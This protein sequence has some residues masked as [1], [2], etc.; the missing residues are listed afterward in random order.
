MAEQVT[1]DAVKEAQSV[2]R[3]APIDDSA[4]STNTRAAHGDATATTSSTASEPSSIAT[5]AT[6][7][8]AEHAVADA[9]GGSDTDISRP[10]SVDQSKRDAGHVRA[11]SMK[12]P[13][14]FKSVSVTKNFLA[15]SV[16]ST[17]TAR[18][19]EKVAPAAPSALAAAPALK[20][21]L[22]AKLGTGNAP[23][24]L[25][26]VNGAGSGPDASKVWNKN[27]PVP[28]PPP[29]QFTDEELKQQYGI[30]LAT[31]LQADEAG[32]EAKWADI[33]DD[34]D[35]WAP[36]TVQWMDGT[37]SS[38]AVAEN[39]PPAVEEAKPVQKVQEAPTEILRP[40]PAAAPNTPKPSVTGGPKTIL[41]PGAHAQPGGKSS[42]VLKGQPE[43]PTLV[44]KPSAS[45]KKSPWA[46]LPPVEKASPIQINPPAQQAPQRFSQ[47]ESYGGYDPMSPLPAKEIAPDDFNRTWRDDNRAR[48]ELF[49]SQSGRYEPVNE[50]RRGSVRDSGFRQQPAVLQRPSQDGPAEPS[51]AFQQSRSAGDT[52]SWGG[53]RR[54]NSSNVSGG[55]RMSFDRRPP[56]MPTGPMGNDRR[57]S[58]SVNGVDPSS[59]GVSRQPSI[60]SPNV[61]HAHPASPYGSVASSG[62]HDQP[63]PT[64]A[65]VAPPAPP[66]EDP[67]EAQK[68]LMADKIERARLKKQQEREADQKEEAERKERLAKRLAAMGPAKVK[69]QMPEKVPEQSPKKGVA[70]PASVQSP[71]KPPVPTADGEIAQYGMMK[72][73]HA[74]PVK[75][76]SQADDTK[77]ATAVSP[78]LAKAQ[79]ANQTRQPPPLAQQPTKPFDSFTR[80]SENSKLSGEQLKGVAQSEAAVPAGPRSQQSQANWQSGTPPQPRPWTS[81]V[82]GPPTKD[83]ALGNG[84]FGSAYDRSQPRG[85]QQQLPVQPQLGPSPA[86][87]RAL[88]PTLSNLQPANAPAAQIQ[89]AQTGP[90]AAQ[91]ASM[92]RPGPIAP[93][94]G[95]KWDN[96]RTLI[97]QNDRE[98]MAKAQQDRERV[99]DAFRPEIRETYKNQLGQSHTTMHEK[100][101][102]NR[103]LPNGVVK[104][105]A[106]KLA[107]DSPSSQPT[108]GQ[109]TPLQQVTGPRASR[110]FPRSTEP[111][112]QP[113]LHTSNKADS[114]PP[115][116]ETESHPAF[117]SRTGHPL[118][119]L[120]K[121]SPVVRL[122]RAAAGGSVQADAPAVTMPPRGT[123]GLGARPLAMNPEWQARFNKLLEKP[124]TS[125]AQAAQA[126]SSRLT[127]V[128][129]PI[130]PAKIGS[131]PIA[132]ASKAA[133]D[134]R[135]NAGSAT[136]SLPNSTHRRKFASDGGD[137]GRDAVTRKGTEGLFEDR[138]FGS[139]P[140]VKLSKA[141]HLAANQPPVT[142]V[143]DDQQLLR[144][145]RMEN[146]FTQRRL[147]AFDHERTAQKI[148][149]VIRLSCMSK[150]VVKTVPRGRRPM[151]VA[152]QYNKPKRNSMSSGVVAG[153]PKDRPRKPSG[154]GQ[155]DRPNGPPRPSTNAWMA[156]KSST[157]GSIPAHQAATTWA[158][159]AAAPVH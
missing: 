153:G 5:N 121:P 44:S 143:D 110:F 25:G 7:D 127:A 35:D 24:T 128:V 100:V 12:K 68:K 116:P 72:V 46:T 113:A 27:Q 137:G 144:F 92:P 123:P 65:P 14:T 132:A 4:S 96:F 57:G 53:G 61:A 74:Q 135:G 87:T 95:T 70:A 45:E 111:A 13:S 17:P 16:V 89:H 119:R 159:R 21:R 20:P 28:V 62:A 39:E 145:K 102:G 49:N 103:G 90:M 11:N 32:K 117:G 124:G 122:P 136:V 36:D 149:V 146:P 138:E 15:K 142:P 64:A 51:A 152:N 104:D 83:R 108:L 84:T 112:S 85:A 60:I 6:G 38:G 109:S 156:S 66:T 88:A 118:V 140:I 33:D 94:S 18:P 139:L 37:K 9:S 155:S 75:K 59:S 148:D 78:S 54:R 29:K 154:Q 81:Q 147:E 31:R 34:E 97:D 157:P 42:L 141:T 77:V 131:L 82:W 23:R 101:G 63:V 105:D 107:H 19:G 151:R 55:R 30:H 125:P 120:P 115:P 22:V 1:N 48:P 129:M 93:Q 43:K 76:A 106:V 3:P 67:V 26:K 99:G 73:H 50:M 133:L 150:A 8:A 41:K 86:A 134:V 40:T 80:E 56:D 69:S 91:I 130:G 98:T 10:G 158:R 58:H 126:A 114:P 71:P 79:T 47:R 52:P 2:G